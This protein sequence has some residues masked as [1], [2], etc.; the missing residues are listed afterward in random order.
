MIPSRLHRTLESRI[1]NHPSPQVRESA[2]PPSA[3]P[4]VA[5]MTRSSTDKRWSIGD[6]RIDNPPSPTYPP[7]TVASHAPMSALPATETAFEHPV[8]SVI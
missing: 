5:P 2:D 7:V 1:S 6:R 3:T 4:I 8:H